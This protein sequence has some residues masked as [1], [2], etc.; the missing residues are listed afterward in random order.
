MEA[1][2]PVLLALLR[3]PEFAKM[4]PMLLGLGSS[5]FPNIPPAQTAAAAAT[6]FDTNGTKWTQTA[7]N[8][9]GEK[10]IVDGSYGEGTKAAVKRF[11]EK[12]GLEPDGWAG[13]KTVDALRR[14]I[15]ASKNV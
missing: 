15:L 10:L 12:N 8:M 3:S 11:Q 4:L 1:L 5:L 13:E 7:L 6:I 9:L 2:L 14:T